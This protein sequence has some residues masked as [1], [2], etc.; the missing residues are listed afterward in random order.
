MKKI[1][2]IFLTTILLF[3]IKTTAQISVNI[4]LGSR[5][6]YNP[7]V[8][9]YYDDNVDYYFL[10][11]IQAYFD[12]RS[13]LFIHYN[14]GGWVR[15]R[16]FDNFDINRCQRIAIEYH[17]NTPYRDFVSHRQQYCNNNRREVVYVENHCNNHN[18][19]YKNK[20]HKN[21]K[22]KRDDDDEDD[23]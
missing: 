9:Y 15:T 1:Q 20:C 8:H 23:D 3:A 17:G 19:R 21:K 12:N 4:S 10:P 14:S 7:P 6:A 16:S 2:L 13:G 22:H 18:N 11:E 5:P